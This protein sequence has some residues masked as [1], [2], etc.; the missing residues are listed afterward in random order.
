MGSP[1][2][3]QAP[4]AETFTPSGAVQNLAMGAEYTQ[5]TGTI[6]GG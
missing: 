4:L 6:L 5:E 1:P 3:D 2:T